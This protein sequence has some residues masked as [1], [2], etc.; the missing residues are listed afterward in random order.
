MR[1]NDTTIIFLLFLSISM[2]IIYTPV[3][4]VPIQDRAL[5][6]LKQYIA[7]YKGKSLSEIPKPYRYRFIV[8][9]AARYVP[10]LPNIITNQFEIDSEK[11]IKFK[12]G[13]INA[14]ALALAALFLF[15]FCLELEFNKATSLIGSML[16]L[17]NF[18]VLNYGGLPI[19][20]A[21]SYFILIICFYA[22]L[23]DHNLLFFLMF[24]FGLFVKETVVLCVVYIFFQKRFR[25]YKI[26]KI[27][28]SLPGL[29][30]YLYLRFLLLPTQQGYNYTFQRFIEANSGYFQSISPWI[31]GFINFL[32]SFG[33]LWI[34]AAKGWIVFRKQKNEEIIAMTRIL[35]VVLAAPFIIGSDLGRIWFNAF[36]LILPMA[37]KGLESILCEELSN[38]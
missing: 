21:F 17:T 29:L 7:I 14:I 34:F 30:A 9:I 4:K 18:Y 15:L 19:V 32:F 28:L 25:P 12:F 1:L 27:L 22:I 26:R 38:Q 24:T 31:Y 23:K 3:T 10:P 20:D 2:G 8:P 37:L 33:I 6:D 16:F 36:P 13:L 11:T 35:A 5:G